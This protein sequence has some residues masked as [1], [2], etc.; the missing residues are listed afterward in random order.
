MGRA[1]ILLAAMGL[2]AGT[3][4]CTM[5][6]HPYDDCGPTFTGGCGDSCDP[7]ARAGSI[8]SGSSMESISGDVVEGE[9]IS[10]RV[11][12][13]SNTENI[14]PSVIFEESPDGSGLPPWEAKSRRGSWSR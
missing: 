13:M 9:V 11:A 4:G 6:A 1:L 2:A 5:C 10:E 7:D 8:L 3:T 14:E 12:P